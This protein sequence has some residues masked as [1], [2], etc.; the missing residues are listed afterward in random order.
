MPRQE[1]NSPE[2]LQP[3]TQ[4]ERTAL[5]E[6]RMIQAAI[7][8]L[9]T[10]GLQGTTAAA[11]GVNAG[12]SRGLAAHHFGT[13]AGLFRAVLKHVSSLW[14]DELVRKLD[15]KTGLEA[16]TT[17]ID[18]HRD[19][20]LRHPEFIRAQHILWGAALDPSSEFKPNVA[21]FMNIQRES[22]EAWIEGG[23]ATGEIRDD[24]DAAHFAEQYYGGLLGLTS[25]WLVGPEFDL[26]AAYENFKRNIVRLLSA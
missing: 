9:N 17:A 13:K 18:A 25:Q 5:A 24:A 10:A 26:A 14:T 8:L 4:A 12:Y 6:A 1:L 3:R 16:I 19:H 11:V 23:K 20:A 22:V 2:N 7:E 15:G 21:E